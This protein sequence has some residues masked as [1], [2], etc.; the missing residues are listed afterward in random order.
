MSKPDETIA[1]SVWRGHGP[2]GGLVRYDVPARDNQTI[3]DIVT[4]IQRNI[5]AA[6]VPLRPCPLHSAPIG[7]PGRRRDAV[8]S[9]GQAPP[10]PLACRRVEG[11]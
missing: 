7:L 11:T 4:Y 6:I 5:D 8:G 9:V 1:V 2:S 3:L 10:R